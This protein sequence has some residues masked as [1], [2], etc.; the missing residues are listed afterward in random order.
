MNKEQIL[1]KTQYGIDI[2]NLIL[3]KYYGE[4][5]ELRVSGMAALAVK[6]PFRNNCETLNVMLQNGAFCYSD[7]Y[8]KEFKG[9]PIKLHSSISN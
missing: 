3:K 8:D 5:Y 7:Q 9:D 2:Y 6:N 1:M 4:G